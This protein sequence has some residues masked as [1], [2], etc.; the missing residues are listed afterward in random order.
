MLCRIVSGCFLR[1]SGHNMLLLFTAFG[2]A[3][4]TRIQYLNQKLMPPSID[5]YLTKIQD[6]SDA[7]VDIRLSSRP[8]LQCSA[9]GVFFNFMDDCVKAVKAYPEC[10]S[11]GSKRENA[12]HAVCYS[13]SVQVCWVTKARD[14]MVVCTCL[15]QLSLNVVR[16]NFNLESLRVHTYIIHYTLWLDLRYV[17]TNHEE[18]LSSK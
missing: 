8:Y 2:S 16:M 17:A 15:S 12:P 13:E 14:Q 4:A 9:I 1:P 11:D 5:Y 7:S 18:S 10:L 6:D 3:T